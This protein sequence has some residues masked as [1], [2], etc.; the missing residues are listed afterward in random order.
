MMRLGH[1]KPV[2][3][4]SRTAQGIQTIIAARA[5]SLDGEALEPQ[6]GA[7]IDSG[8]KRDPDDFVC[9][10]DRHPNGPRLAKP[11]LVERSEI[12]RVPSLLGPVKY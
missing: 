1:F 9:G 4:K 10:S 12:E 5:A 2:N 11:G 7:V 8:Q 6:Y 3:V